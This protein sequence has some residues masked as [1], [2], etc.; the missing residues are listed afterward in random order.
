M[1]DTALI[2]WLC[3]MEHQARSGNDDTRY[4]IPQTVSEAL[5]ARGWIQ[6]DP[7]DWRG[8]HPTELTE[9]GQTVFDLNAAE[10]GLEVLVDG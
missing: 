5:L 1:T 8:V 3:F 7:E 9:L 6:S 2:G 10:W 4:G